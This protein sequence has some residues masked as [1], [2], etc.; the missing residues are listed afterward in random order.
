MNQNKLRL[1]SLFLILAIGIFLRFYHITTVPPSLSH[2]EVAIA[3]NSYSILKTGKDEYGKS[4][5]LLF[6]SFDD[7]KLPGMVYINIP[8]VA[9]FGR[10]AMGARFTSAFLGS[11]TILVLYLLVY[12]LMKNHRT[13][14]WLYALSA[15]FFLAIS[16]WHINFSRQLFESNGALFFLTLA[17]YVLLKSFTNIRLLFI[18]SLLF[19][20]SIYFYYS[21][22]LVI[23]FII[24]A[25]CLINKKQLLT[26]A[27]LVIV[28]LFIFLLTIMPIGKLMFSPDGLERVSI[29]SIVNDPNYHTWKDAFVQRYAKNQTRLNKIFFNQKTAL[30]MTAVDNY[31]KNIT[32][33]HIFE[34]G[35]NTYGL[36]HPFEIPLIFI[37]ILYMATYAHPAKWIIIAWLISSFL[38]GALSTN[39]PNALRTLLAAPIFSLFSGI[40]AVELL[41][42]IE[43]RKRLLF[44]VAPFSLLIIFFMYTFYQSY[45]IVNPTRN[46]LAFADGYEQMITYVRTHESSY[47]RIVISGYYWR[48]YI[49]MLYWGN[50]D[51]IMYQ[52]KGTKNGWGKYVFTGA[53]WDKNEVF[54]YNSSYDPKKLVLT[55][56]EKT[57]FIL[58][59]LEYNKNKERY[60][61]INSISG[62][63]EPE[64]FIAALTK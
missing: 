60:Q 41:G 32:P 47:D 8:A 39:Q 52:Q 21:V 23:P 31:W 11:L 57:L 29:V 49:F 61:F 25:Y 2:D 64:V 34:S 63:N 4:Y 55:T 6:Q 10:T 56:A 15:A 42:S 37:G 3:Y 1:I 5:P 46:A 59:S 33:L 18:S 26:H 51:P 28:A 30:I 43:K 13:N 19:G 20:V 17:T 62:R 50:V 38:P 53:E 54:L 12:E 58:G 7:Y 35:T 9:L 36:Q 24:L 48:P 44:G 27:R 22:R 45:F 14:P 40:G 16:P